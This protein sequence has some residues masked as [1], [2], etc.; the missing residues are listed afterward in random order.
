MWSIFGKWQPSTTFAPSRRRYPASAIPGKLNLQLKRE[1]KLLMMRQ[2]ELKDFQWLV[3][4][5]W[6]NNFPHGCQDICAGSTLPRVNW[7]PQS[8]NPLHS[9]TPNKRV[10]E[11]L[12]LYYQNLQVLPIWRP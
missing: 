9:E 10:T 7:A 5:G 11:P 3:V 8:I 6:L 1:R 4:S 2:H 12:C